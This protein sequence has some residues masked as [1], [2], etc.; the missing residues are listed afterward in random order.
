M[1]PAGHPAEQAFGGIRR[2][3]DEVVHVIPAGQIQVAAQ[4]AV[5]RVLH[6]HVH[7]GAALVHHRI[8]FGAHLLRRAVDAGQDAGV[9]AGGRVELISPRRGFDG[10]TAGP[11]Q[12]YIAHHDLAGDAQLRRHHTGTDRCVGVAQ[13]LQ[14]HFSALYSIHPNAPLFSDFTL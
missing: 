1:H 12:G 8:Q 9:A 4:L 10:R 11:Q 5:Q 2:L 6:G 3:L 7:H 13:P 14:Y